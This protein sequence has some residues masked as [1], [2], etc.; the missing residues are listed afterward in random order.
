MSVFQHVFY[1]NI[2]FYWIKGDDLIVG[3]DVL[4]FLI[5]FVRIMFNIMYDFLILY[6]THN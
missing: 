3:H 6:M 4:C 5:H 2:Y 1:I